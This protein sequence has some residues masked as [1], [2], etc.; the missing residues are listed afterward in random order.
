[1]S[2]AVAVE[3][4]GMPERFVLEGTETD[5]G[6]VVSFGPRVLCCSRSSDSGLRKLA[7]VTLCGAGCRVS[8]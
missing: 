6:T 7:V 2:M 8:R 5:N 4:E 3:L 1:M